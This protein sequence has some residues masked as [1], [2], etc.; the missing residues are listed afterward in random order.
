MHNGKHSKDMGKIS[1]PV[2][3]TMLRQR[4]GE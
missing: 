4:V 2:S 1:R 3:S